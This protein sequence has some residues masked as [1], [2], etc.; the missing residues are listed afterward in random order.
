M[1][2]VVLTKWGNSIGLRIPATIIKEAH[3]AAGNELK[4]IVNQDNS[5]TLI[6]VNNAQESWTEQFNAAA[7]AKQDRLL[8]DLPNEF[9][10]E[11]WT[12]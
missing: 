7:D 1:S 6:P 2:T 11:E 4:M 9:D 12:W 3:L 8:L 10:E 5:F